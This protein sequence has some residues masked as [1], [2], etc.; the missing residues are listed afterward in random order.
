MGDGNLDGDSDA[1]GTGERAA[2]GRDTPQADGSDIDVD[3]V[4]EDGVDTGE[5]AE[6]LAEEGYTEDEDA[7]GPIPP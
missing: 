1:A 7:R 5:R 3:H 6:S 4:E 2:A